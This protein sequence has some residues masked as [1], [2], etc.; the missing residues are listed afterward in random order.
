V[1]E[2]GG[3]PILIRGSDMSNTIPDRK[4]TLTFLIYLAS[5]LLLLREEV[6]AAIKIQSAWRR[7]I[8]RREKKKL[9]KKY[10]T[11]DL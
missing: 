7:A 2:L 9:K 3:V 10:S 8:R 11:T 6:S 4:V 5:R 1:N